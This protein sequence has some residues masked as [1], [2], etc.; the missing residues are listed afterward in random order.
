MGEFLPSVREP[1]RALKIN[2]P[3]ERPTV[4]TLIFY[5]E[6]TGGLKIAALTLL[7]RL[8]VAVHRAGVSSI[9][10]V[11]RNDPLEL[12]RAAALGVPVRIVAES[13]SRE[14]A[15]LVASASV[16][17]QTADVKALL[18]QGGRLATADGTPLSIGV[19]PPGN[20]D[21]EMAL[22]RL[23]TRVAQGVAERVPDNAAARAAEQLLWASL[24]SSTDGLVDK[25]FNRPG[26]RILSK[27]L[28][29]TSISPNFVSLAS[30][31]IGLAAA[32]CFAVGSYQVAVIGALLF[33]LSAIVDC[34][35][36]DLAR[37]LFKESPLGKWLDLAGDQVVHVAV[38]A[39]VAIGLA[40]SGE[41]PFA[42]W[43]GVSAVLGAALSFAVVLRG[44]RQPAEDRNALLQKLIDSAANRD[45]SV[46]VLALACFNR[47][48]WFL[49]LSAIG[50][51]VFWMTALALQTRSGSREGAAR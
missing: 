51:H 5:D 28:I 12:K 7:D 25:V 37:V 31:A 42:L 48:E 1:E 38:F 43:L 19:L 29:H 49:W 9:T 47:L 50:S 21:W 20:D 39:A 8:V 34:V 24:T 15:T 32:W 35:D 18:E 11:A 4:P 30:I 3:D 27:L 16:L 13:P 10:V 46:L 14:I 44:M 23:P 22:D 33:Q 45:F 2:S 36:G 17:V 41:S 40:R 26:G 6:H